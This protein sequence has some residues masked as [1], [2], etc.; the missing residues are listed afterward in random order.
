M[1]IRRR[2]SAGFSLI[3]MMITVSLLSL[4]I[5]SVA[6]LGNSNDRAY[7]TGAMAAYLEAKAAATTDQIVADLAIAGLESLSPDP[8]PGVGADSIQYLQATGLT[9]GEVEWSS[10]RRLAF[11]YE[12]GELDD[13]LD[14]NGN[15]L[16]DEGRVILTEDVGG[17][18]EKSHVLTRWVREQFDGEEANGVDDNGNG[19]V[20]ERGFFVERIGETLVV[21]L[22]LQR[23]N[24]EGLP[25]NRTARTSTRLRN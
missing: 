7:R 15:G 2:Q 17:P 10:L 23:L 20:D 21:R 9:A 1:Q 3:E 12:I 19:L 16:I 24:A 6:L 13:G 5:G 14:N 8:I 25:M 11:E 18:D 4:V 22:T